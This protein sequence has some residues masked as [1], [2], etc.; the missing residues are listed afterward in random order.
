[1]QLALVYCSRTLPVILMNSL[2]QQFC[3]G[4]LRIFNIQNPTILP[5]KFYFFLSNL[6]A[7]SYPF[8]RAIDY[9]FSYNRTEAVLPRGKQVFLKFLKFVHFALVYIHKSYRSFT[10]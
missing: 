5:I 1:M 9:S 8:L 3:S 6:S 4:F 10:M 2:I 7:Y